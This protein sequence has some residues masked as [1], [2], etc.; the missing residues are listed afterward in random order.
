[1]CIIQMFYLYSHKLYIK[2]YK[3]NQILSENILELILSSRLI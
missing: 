3:I 1:M 2:I